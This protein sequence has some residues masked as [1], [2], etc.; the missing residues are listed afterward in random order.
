[1]AFGHA[2]DAYKGPIVDWDGLN[3]LWTGCC[4]SPCCPK[5]CMHF[6]TV[7]ITDTK[8]ISLTINGKKFVRHNSE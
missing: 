4:V 8:G 3:G 5:G 7:V 6:E 1:M 2:H